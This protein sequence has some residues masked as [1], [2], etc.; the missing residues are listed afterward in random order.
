MNWTGGNLQRFS[1]KGRGKSNALTKIQKEHFARQRLRLQN[2]NTA[3][4]QL[5]FEPFG[6][7]ESFI[8]LSTKP[9]DQTQPQ[10][11]PWNSKI[12]HKD[13]SRQTKLEDYVSTVSVANRLSNM[14]QRP[15][16]TVRKRKLTHQHLQ[17]HDHDGHNFIPPPNLPKTHRTRY[18]PLNQKSSGRPYSNSHRG[19]HLNTTGSANPKFSFLGENNWAG[20]SATA[21][22]EIIF[23]SAKERDQVG[24]R[25]KITKED[26]VRKQAPSRPMYGFNLT[27]CMINGNGPN[28]DDQISVLDDISIRIGKPG[29]ATRSSAFEDDRPEHILLGTQ[30]SSD[31][32]LLDKEMADLRTLTPTRI[33]VDLFHTPQRSSPGQCSTWVG[34]MPHQ[35]SATSSL[36]PTS[37]SLG[38]PP[39]PPMRKTLRPVI[40]NRLV[41]REPK[42]WQNART[43]LRRML[44]E[45]AAA[46]HHHTGFRFGQ[47]TP[48]QGN[49]SANLLQHAPK[50]LKPTP[51]QAVWQCRS[52]SSGQVALDAPKGSSP[53][54]TGFV[55][56]FGIAA[57]ST[58]LTY[59]SRDRPNGS[60]GTEVQDDGIDEKETS[61]V[62]GRQSSM[63]DEESGFEPL[64]AA[65]E[66]PRSKLEGIEGTDDSQSR[67]CSGNSNQSISQGAAGRESLLISLKWPT[68]Q[69]TQRSAVSGDKEQIAAE[70]ESWV[71]FIFGNDFD[72]PFTERENKSFD[73]RD[74]KP[75]E[76]NKPFL[77]PHMQT[78]D[79]SPEQLQVLN[80]DDSSLL[81]E[82]HKLGAP[83]ATRV[84]VD[85]AQESSDIISSNKSLRGSDDPLPSMPQSRG[86]STPPLLNKLLHIKPHETQAQEGH[87]L[88]EKPTW[89]FT[90]TVPD[91]GR[92]KFNLYFRDRRSNQVSPGSINNNAPNTTCMEF[93]SPTHPTTDSLNNPR[94][95]RSIP[96]GNLSTDQ[97]QKVVFSRPRPF[98]GRLKE[99]E[100]Q[101]AHEV[102]YIGR[103]AV[104]ESA[105]QKAVGNTT[106]Q[107]SVGFRMPRQFTSPFPEDGD[108]IESVSDI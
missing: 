28:T 76:N 61:P 1:N 71:R 59:G 39:L 49:D 87:L 60:V 86:K 45:P 66:D 33:A 18:P 73:R 65:H 81:T 93:S 90:P 103:K 34:K 64:D 106:R 50:P 31:S 74:V 10:A 30:N 55:D 19:P 16:A 57:D 4:S 77:T 9:P 32:M 94:I 84:S 88:R 41:G 98:V 58:S 85:V 91:V 79:S 99:F 12:R 89:R 95:S 102:V 46:N 56:H 42:M 48:R 15:A 8:D 22:A 40:P 101:R 13:E 107:L 75:H 105:K 11:A 83:S 82:P 21:P 26:L 27:K 72:K 43:Q 78:R 20:I 108:D 6:G 80:N 25:R 96:I 17:G 67:E 47:S 104:K 69:V 62:S 14:R 44:L 2:G 53:S 92:T 63:H 29:R 38:T 7:Q 100:S 36:D 70:D 68:K 23:L 51:I 5:K 35:M 3:P 37:N 54:W 97:T 24:K 52:G